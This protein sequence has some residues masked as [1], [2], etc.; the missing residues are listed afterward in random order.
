MSKP[1]PPIKNIYP[2]NNA[3]KPE[4]EA[5]ALSLVHAL[6]GFAPDNDKEAKDSNAGHLCPPIDR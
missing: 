6:S 5:L 2:K 1:L 4:L 3:S